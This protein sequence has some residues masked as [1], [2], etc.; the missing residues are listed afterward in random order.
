MRSKAASNNSRFPVFVASN[1][2]KQEV[3]L[4]TVS[5]YWPDLVRY[6]DCLPTKTDISGQKIIMISPA[7]PI[8]L[9][10]SYL[11]HKPLI[12]PTNLWGGVPHRRAGWFEILNSC[13]VKYSFVCIQVDVNPAQ[14]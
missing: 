12:M 6:P 7:R 9:H 1:W 3:S 2:A 11:T 10:D 5:Y 4:R 14:P 8:S 13:L